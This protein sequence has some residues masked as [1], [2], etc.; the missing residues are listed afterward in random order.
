MKHLVTVS[1]YGI[2]LSTFKI[3][4]SLC[5]DPVGSYEWGQAEGRLR[6]LP[7]CGGTES[8]SVRTAMVRHSPRTAGQGSGRTSAWLSRAMARQGR[9]VSGLETNNMAG[10]PA[11]GVLGPGVSLEGNR[12]GLSELLRSISALRS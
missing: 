12:W 3:N 11:H 5:P 4:G 2:C 8:N 6:C 1:K 10:Q 9:E 7:V